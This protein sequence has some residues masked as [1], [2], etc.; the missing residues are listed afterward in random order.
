MDLMGVCDILYRSC[1]AVVTS[2]C[3]GEQWPQSTSCFSVALRPQDAAEGLDLGFL[4]CK[5]GSEL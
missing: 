1:C 5:V 2:I 4:T 3:S